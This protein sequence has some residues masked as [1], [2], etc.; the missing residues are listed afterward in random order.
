MTGP[1]LTALYDETV[2][3]YRRDYAGLPASM[4]GIAGSIILAA[5]IAVLIEKIGR[6]QVSAILHEIVADQG[7]KP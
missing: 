1:N 6:E 3:D 4:T 5:H 2:A 7:L